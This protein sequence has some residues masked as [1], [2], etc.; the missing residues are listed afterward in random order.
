M[1]LREIKVKSDHWALFP[2]SNLEA[3]WI[4]RMARIRLEDLASPT[5]GPRAHLSLCLCQTRSQ[6][7]RWSWAHALQS[8]L[9]AED[10]LSQG[11]E[12]AQRL[13]LNISKSPYMSLEKQTILQ[14][15][16][17]RKFKGT[18]EDLKSAINLMFSSSKQC[19]NFL[20]LLLSFLRWH[21]WFRS[22]AT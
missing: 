14:A 12:E 13:Q 4:R 6:L 21:A 19:P 1:K 22:P 17:N 5:P 3:G 9:P 11:L 18:R 7:R 8:Q 10:W 15:R 2:F 20:L 16:I